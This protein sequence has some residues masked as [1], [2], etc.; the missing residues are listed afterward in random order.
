MN[1]SVQKVGIPGIPGC[2][3]HAYSIWDII[4]EAKV[5]KKDLKVVWL[6]LG[7]AYG[8]VPHELL[9][10]AMEFFHI[11]EN[12]KSIMQNYYNK[13]RMR[14]ATENFT[15]DW[16]RLEVGIGAGCIT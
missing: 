14:F 3:E 7:N 1:G 2:I 4:Q 13:F 8:S 6:D 11:P 12:V 10:K 5:N 16:H 15:T 9:F